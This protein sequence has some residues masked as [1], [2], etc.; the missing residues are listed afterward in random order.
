MALRYLVAPG[1][2]V[3]E[4]HERLLRDDPIWRKARIRVAYER[5]PATEFWKRLKI[6]SVRVRPD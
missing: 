1:A 6:E 3:K 2:S 5:D 4:T